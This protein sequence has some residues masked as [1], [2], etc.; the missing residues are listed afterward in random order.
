MS[1]FLKI[2][3]PAL[4][5][6]ASVLTV[7]YVLADQ[8][9]T[10]M[11]APMRGAVSVSPAMA[12]T[13]PDTADA[14]AAAGTV[15]AAPEVNEAVEE[16]V[17]TAEEAG[18]AEVTEES[19]EAEEVEETPE[20]TEAEEAEPEAEPQAAEAEADEA[21]TADAEASEAADEP[22]APQAEGQ[23]IAAASV[24]GGF[25][26]GRPALEEEVA[27]WDIDVRPDGLGLPVGSGDVWTGEELYVERCASCH[28]DFGEAVGR[29]PVLAGGQGS[30][31]KD[32]PVKTIGSYW[33]YLSTVWDYVHRAMPFGEAQ[34]L[35]DDEVYAITAYLLYLN[36]LVG[37]DFVLSNETFSEVSMPNAEAFYMDDR[38]EVEL[39][40][41]SGEVC[42]TDCKENVEITA[43]AAVLDVTPEGDGGGASLDEG[44]APAAAESADSGVTEADA[45]AVPAEAG[46]A[47]AATE[48]EAA[49]AEEATGTEEATD[50]TEGEAAEGET[51]T[52]TAAAATDATAEPAPEAPAAAADPEL[53]AA[54][55]KVWRQC[56]SCHQ[57]G[58]GAVNRTGPH[59]NGLVGRT[60]GSVEGFRY[61]NVFQ[62]AQE[63][64]RVWDM[65][66]LQE[67]LADPRG[68]M[69][70]TKMSFR[71]LNNPE[72]I[73][74]VVAYIEDAG[75]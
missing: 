46:E 21:D 42:M 14:D 54:G 74:A 6:A 16:T 69:P 35:S 64:G 23:Q 62:E 50:A 67:F 29:W 22:A 18:E 31:T 59:L 27:A 73:D 39:P 65:A 9:V 20:V 30:L 43:R 41:F 37:D 60:V 70:G 61:S 51:G 36:D 68:S 8:F 12:Q 10:D 44:G 57:L 15:V 28:G 11:P 52:D 55:E 32:R 25:G 2:I 1:K 56:R 63:A 53:I 3:T 40:K 71:G 58:E 33:P 34:S 26:L 48:A 47:D 7:A 38:A 75:N 72:D 45:E 5:G 17:E 66:F 13:T 4:G 49:P 19:A 24:E